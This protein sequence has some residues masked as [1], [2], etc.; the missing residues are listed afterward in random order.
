MIQR[1]ASDAKALFAKYYPLWI[2]FLTCLL[3]AFAAGVAMMW[4]TA[5][6]VCTVAFK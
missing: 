5:F 2:A 6:G 4:L 3:A 1:V